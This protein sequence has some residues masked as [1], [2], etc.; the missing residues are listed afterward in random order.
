MSIKACDKESAKYACEG[1]KTFEG[2]GLDIKEEV[3]D[4]EIASKIL[5]CIL[6][7]IFNIIYRTTIGAG[8]PKSLCFC[9]PFV[10]T[11]QTFHWNLFSENKNHL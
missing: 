4:Q 10:P 11:L 7:C 5:F 3:M 8:D 6:L 2:V 1:C 9:S